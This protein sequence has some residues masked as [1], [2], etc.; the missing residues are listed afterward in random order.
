VDD[1]LFCCP[2]TGEKTLSQGPIESFPIAGAGRKGWNQCDWS[3][4]RKLVRRV[5]YARRR[6]LFKNGIYR[7]YVFWRAPGRPRR[8]PKEG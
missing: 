4:R 5:A 3:R 2:G 6:I 7:V 1:G 8:R